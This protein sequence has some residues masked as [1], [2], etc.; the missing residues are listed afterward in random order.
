MNKKIIIAIDGPAG[1]GKTSSAKL[2]AEVLNYKYID[3]GAMYRA[4]SLAWLNLGLAIEE[5]FAIEV[6][7][8]VVLDLEPSENGQKTILNGVD[9]SDA[10]RSQ[11]VT[12]AVSPI[13]AMGTVREKMIAMQREMGK[14]G[15]IVMDGRD[16]GTVV[17][18]QA[19]LKIF[20]TATSEERALRRF[21]ELQAKGINADFDELHKQIIARDIYDETR[22]LSPMKPAED[23]IILDTTGMSLTE[24]VDE[25]MNIIKEKFN[26]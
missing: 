10:I 7:E 6:L 15:G 4:V 22:E 18:P 3:T 20:F 12:K 24:Q 8:K 9:V 2:I 16:I 17:F 26:Q 21:R 1:S 11:E 5:S 14:K 23:A 25:V 13:S 19:E